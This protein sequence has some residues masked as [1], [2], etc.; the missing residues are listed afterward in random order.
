VRIPSDD[1]RH[2]P[3]APP[4]ITSANLGNEQS[5]AEAQ[6]GRDPCRLKLRGCRIVDAA[7]IEL[8]KEMTG[9][10]NAL[11]RRIE[12]LDVRGAAAALWP[13]ERGEHRH[14]HDHDDKSTEDRKKSRSD[15]AEFS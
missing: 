14:R 7:R 6:G 10:W 12:L 4:S 11:F 1:R 3:E 13:G 8:G 9:T 5:A 2:E 15:G